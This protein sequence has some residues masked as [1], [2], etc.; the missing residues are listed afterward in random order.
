MPYPSW[1]PTRTWWGLNAHGFSKKKALEAVLTSC[2]FPTPLLVL[3]NDLEYSGKKKIRKKAIS[4]QVCFQGDLPTNMA[5]RQALLFSLVDSEAEIWA[6]NGQV[7]L[8]SVCWVHVRILSQRY[9]PRLWIE[10]SQGS[11]CLLK[12]ITY[13]DT[14]QSWWQ[15]QWQ[16]FHVLS[17]M[18]DIK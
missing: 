4:F 3:S 1:E 18:A 9:S 15:F 6:V 17:K 8:S 14:F 7:R 16:K 12:N 5:I 13:T 2:P 10:S 11:V